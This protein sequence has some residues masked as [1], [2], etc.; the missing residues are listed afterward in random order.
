VSERVIG[1]AKTSGDDF[2]KLTVGIITALPKEYAAVR[3]LLESQRPLAVPGRGGGRQYLYSEIPARDGGRHKMVLALLPDMGNNFASARAALLVEH[4]PSIH[5]VVMT[6]IAGGVPNPAEPG[7]HVRLGDIVVSNRQGV[8]QYDFDKE[9]LT[10]GIV[11]TIHRHPPR[12]P[13]ASLIESA[14]LLEAGEYE[15]ERPWERYI[16]VVLE[17]MS[18]NRPPS[19][20]DVLASTSNPDE[21]LPHPDDPQR[22]PGRPRVFSGPIASANK[23]LKNPV[24]RDRLRDEFGVKAVEM[25]GSGI[26]DATW[27]AEVGYMVVRGICD[28]CDRNKG[29]SWQAYAAAVAAAYTRALLESTPAQLSGS[30]GERQDQGAPPDGGGINGQDVPNRAPH[31]DAGEAAQKRR[32]ALEEISRLLDEHAGEIEAALRQGLGKRISIASGDEIVESIGRV[33]TEV[34]ERGVDRVRELIGG[35]QVGSAPPRAVPPAPAVIVPHDDD[36]AAEE[37]PPFANPAPPPVENFVGRKSVSD[38]VETAARQTRIIALVGMLGVGKSAF[39]RQVAARFDPGSVFWHSFTAGLVSLDDVLMR[40]AR[41][42]EGRPGQQSDL[43]TH[44]QSASLSLQGRIELLIDGLNNSEYRLFFDRVNLAETEASFNGFFSLLKERLRKGTVFVTDRSTPAFVSPTDETRG[45]AKV[46]YMPGLDAAEVRDFLSNKNVDVSLE[47]AEDLANGLSGLPLALELLVALA[48]DKHSEEELKAHAG[49][50]REQVVEHLFEE[51]YTRLDAEERELLTNASLLRLPFTKAQILGIHKAESGQNAQAAFGRLWR[52]SLIQAISDNLYQV[53]EVVAALA[54]GYASIDQ[55]RR[56]TEIAEHLLEEM[57]DDVNAHLEVVLLYLH[58][59]DFDRAAEV[60]SGMMDR[61][62][63][64]SNPDTA[65]TLISAFKED[66]VS[67]ERW[68]WLLGDKGRIADFWRRAGEAGR[69]YRDML[70]LAKRLGN[71]RAQAIALLRLGVT[72]YDRDNKM[73]EEFYLEALKIQEEAGD[74]DGQAD[75]YNNLGLLYSEQGEI[76]KARAVFTKGLDLRAAAGAPEWRNLGFNSNLGIMYA[77]QGQWEEAFKYSMEALRIAEGT[78][79]PY[80]IAKASYNLGRH[81]AERGNADAAREQYLRVLETAEEYDFWEVEDLVCV[82]L[83]L[84]EYGLKRYD[85]AIAYFQRVADVREQIEDLEGLSAIQFDTGT[86]YSKKGDLDGALEYYAHGLANFEHITDESQIDIYLRNVRSLAAEQ[87]RP[88]IARQLVELL[89]QLKGRLSADGP[90][91]TLASM[92]WSL[93]KIYLDNLGMERVAIACMR[94]SIKILSQLGRARERCIL[95]RDLGV[96]YQELGL[97]GDALRA[98]GEALKV[99]VDGVNDLTGGIL[100]NTGNCYV[101]LDMYERAEE[102]YRRALDVAEEVED[103]ELASGV[104]HNLGETLRHLNN[105]E[106]AMALTRSS[107]DF[108]REN[109]DAVGEVYALNNLGL[110]YQGLSQQDEA[111]KYFNEA[112]SVARSHSLHRDEANTLISL[113]NFHLQDEPAVAKEYYE[114]ALIAARAA[115]DVDMEEGAMLSLA[116]AHRKLGTTDEIAQELKAVAERANELGHNEHFVKFL[117][118][119]GEVN[120]EEGEAESAADMFE[121]ALAFATLAMVRDLSQLGSEEDVRLRFPEWTH[122]LGRL[123]A[124]LQQA[125]ED[126]KLELAGTFYRELLDKVQSAEYWGGNNFMLKY[127]L[128]IGEYI[129]EPRDEPMWKYVTEAWR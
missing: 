11:E 81:E 117:V 12:P 94:Q 25:E 16:D 108:A 65:E 37:R 121:K 60:A 106:G 50:A 104:R 41:Y 49:R 9:V 99:A 20:T 6:G 120:L 69:H 119:A 45:T 61:H 44:M 87:E 82:A 80:D 83:G 38:D 35:P 128:P 90:S 22:R 66:K 100:F 14:R 88:E 10:G 68:V 84:L 46:I 91:Y 52:K 78:G 13:S 21:A 7:E 5:T 48:G 71:K 79:S 19:E 85:E 18:V 34:W 75:I 3:A 96:A 115:E 39:M 77:K 30:D 103:R 63:L 40:L 72:Y 76:E 125:L 36:A 51:V 62:L 123:L 58:A 116:Y 43:A 109:G 27:N 47:T 70:E 55:N 86:F 73:A 24:R 56:R 107:L 101:E 102:V 59:N 42:L 114:Q 2:A 105:P 97:Y 118:L 89:K 15:G 67:P 112:L 93:G 8:V 127:L 4:F 110:S 28:Y 98:N 54:L 23:L 1:A 111:L 29:D 113:G 26:A 17:R 32:T 57:P 31:E 74:L 122:A 64:Y 126:G 129:S 124:S 33:N 92:Y 53:H 95:L